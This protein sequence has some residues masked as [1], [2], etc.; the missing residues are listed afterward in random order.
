MNIKEQKSQ[1]NLQPQNTSDEF[2]IYST[3]INLI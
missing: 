3:V 2:L 1:E